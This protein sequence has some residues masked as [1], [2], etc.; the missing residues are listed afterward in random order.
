MDDDIAAGVVPKG[1]KIEPWDWLYYAERM[2]KAQKSVS[3]EEMK[4]YFKLK[5]VLN[6]VFVA[7]NTLYGI[8]VE[9]VP[10]VPSYSPGN[11]VAYK[12]TDVDGSFLGI[13]I[14]DVHPRA[15]KASGAW[16]SHIRYQ[17][18]DDNG[19]D[20]RPIVINACNFGDNLTPNQVSTVFHEFGHALHCL[21]SKCKYRNMSGT[22]GHM[23]YVE[24]F[25]QFNEHWA[26]EPYLL[27]Q[28][29]VDET[30]GRSMPEELIEQTREASKFLAGIYTSMYV[31]SALLDLKIHLL[32]DFAGFDPEKF[33]KSVREEISLPDE[34]WPAHGLAHFKHIFVNKYQA[35]YFS[36]T[37][38]EVLELNL[39]AEFEKKGD[40][41]NKELA[42]RFRKTFLET[43]ATRDP[44]ELFRSFT[45]AEP[46]ADK[47]FEAK[48]LLK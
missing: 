29:A 34:L 25:S 9:E 44:M 47:F 23:D 10:E 18:V 8:S 30:T 13:V 20:V 41:W 27:K 32:E 12:V 15:T 48:G 28:Y 38:A 22:N 16:N 14:F 11:T 21:L 5:N 3:N 37:W 26:V 39:F 7:A 35:G 6:G 17:M 24:I 31:A 36:Y 46:S 40:V 45:G 2:R 4:K 33:E 42:R 19:N 1:A 43:G